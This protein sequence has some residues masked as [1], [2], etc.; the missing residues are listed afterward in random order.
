MCF[1]ILEHDQRPMKI[2]GE[3]VIAATIIPLHSEAI[4]A[5][6]YIGA[7]SGHVLEIK[8]VGLLAD[9]I[10]KA[11]PAYAAMRAVGVTLSKSGAEAATDDVYVP[12]E[13]YQIVQAWHGDL[14]TSSNWPA[15]LSGYWLPATFEIGE[16]QA[17]GWFRVKPT[18]EVEALLVGAWAEKSNTATIKPRYAVNLTVCI[19][20]IQYLNQWNTAQWAGQSFLLKQVVMA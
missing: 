19:T 8:S 10:S 17:E 7:H 15:E 1:L 4:S 5:G 13:Q 18:Q 6:L 14:F 2:R 16:E 20:S 11:R 12:L 3:Q 9:A